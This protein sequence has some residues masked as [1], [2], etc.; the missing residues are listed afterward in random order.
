[1]EQL[2]NKMKKYL[3][4]I[5]LFISI[6]NNLFS[7]T[8]F[9]F[10]KSG[11]YGP[12][13]TGYEYVA[14]GVNY[15]PTI[16]ERDGTVIF[17]TGGKLRTVGGWNP[18]LFPPYSTTNQQWETPDGSAFTQIADAGFTGRHNFA[19]GFRTN[20]DFWTWGGD[21]N[22]IPTGQRD[23]WKCV[24]GTWSQVT[25]DWGNV[26][27]DRTEASFC[28]HN[29]YMYLIGGSIADCV[30]S[31]D[32]ITWT[33][34]SDLPAALVSVNYASG[35]AC[36]H[37][38]Y[39]YVLGG[40]ATGSNG[41]Q[42]KVFRTANGTTWDQLPDL[43]ASTALT[44]K[45]CRVFSW[46]DRLWYFSGTGSS[47]N[48]RG[49]WCSSDEGQTWVKN[50][51]FFM[52]ATHA[53][54]I[55]TF[56]NDLYQVTGNASPNSNKIYRV[57]YS[58]LSNKMVHSVRKAVSTYTGSCMKVR[59]SSDNA[60]Q[61]IG[62][63][64]G[65]LDTASLR[66]FVG[67]N[68]GYVRTWY[69]QSGNAIDLV[70]TSSSLQPLIRDAGATYTQNGKAAIYFDATNKYLTYTTAK[71]LT[72]KYTISAVMNLNSG[73]RQFGYCTGNYYLF[74]SDGSSTYHSTQEL[75]SQRFQKYVSGY[76]ITRSA[77]KLVEI[78]RNRNT[79]W[80]YE[81]GVYKLMDGDF[82]GTIS[83][84][85]TQ[86]DVVQDVIQIGGEAGAASFTGYLQELNIK[87]GV[88]EPTSNV[89]IQADINGFFGIY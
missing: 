25:A 54:G 69:D 52:L 14:T 84:T 10:W 66:T 87:T 44:T 82:T 20:G 67:A 51:S 85:R 77:Q 31:S 27:G 72:S 28:V 18:A 13:E 64:N 11:G 58:A 7:Q 73:T 83:G 21:G 15:T 62:F 6:T 76:V 71:P 41:D 38:G 75:S 53:Q 32:G 1:M 30:R 81:N 47:G 78:Y 79:G 59:R 86:F 39:I 34:M 9:A 43:P 45:W 61:D 22:T 57:A 70:Q 80:F 4:L 19:H 60:E 89:S 16:T 23:V 3:V 74:Y 2:G 65:Y 40:S 5:A 56:G 48:Q 36:S 12:I 35:Y 29:D 46:A 37:R 55:G 24:A 33:K 8:P 50:Y 26:A 88:V 68:T 63:V 42:Y 17:E 49:I